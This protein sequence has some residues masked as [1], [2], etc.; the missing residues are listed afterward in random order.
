MNVFFQ[1]LRLRRKSQIGW[2]VAIV[3][4]MLL[5][6]IKF[7]TLAQDASMSEALLKQFPATVQAIFGMTGLTLTTLSGYFGVLFIYIL[8]ILSIHAGMLGAGVLADE[9]RDRTT[10]FLLVK[11]RSRVTIII[12]KLLA[13][14]VYVSVLWGVVVVTTLVSI[15]SLSN[16]GDF[17]RDFWHFMIALALTQVAVFFLGSF[18]AA[19]TK[20][21]KLPARFV[22]AVVFVSYLLFALVKLS[23]NLDGLKYASLFY[24]FDAVSIINDGTIQLLSVVVFCVI[25]LI[26]LV[27]TF[28]FYRRRDV[29]V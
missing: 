11:P 17:I 6:V 18:A 2:I 9:E 20:N 25:A 7:D 29:N 14:V 21:P 23:P 16:T 5:S 1:E 22:A 15:V 12:Q 19:I 4:F 8:V 24:Y 13:G 3:I 10:E 28:V 27:G 26:A